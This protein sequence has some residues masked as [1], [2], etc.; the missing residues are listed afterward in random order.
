MSGG[1]YRYIEIEKGEIEREGLGRGVGITYCG[2]GEN[3]R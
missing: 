3:L 2:G 1:I